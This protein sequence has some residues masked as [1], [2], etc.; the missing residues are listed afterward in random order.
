MTNNE[1]NPV[2]KRINSIQDSW[3]K[4]R[5]RLPHVRLF[6]LLFFQEDFTFVN[7]FLQ[8]E[9]SAHGKTPDTFVVFMHDFQN[10]EQF[11]KTLLL[12]WMSTFEKEAK[13]NPQW[14]WDDLPAL[15]EEFYAIEKTDKPPYLQLTNKLLTSFKA[16]EGK[17]GNLLMVGFVPK[18][19]SN[20]KEYNKAI[21]ALF[22]LLPDDVGLLVLDFNESEKHKDI[23]K[24]VDDKGVTIVIPNQDLKSTYKEL[25]SQGNPNDPQVK[26]RQ[27][28]L[29]M[30][31]ASAN[32]NRK[33]V[34]S[35]GKKMLDITQAT[36]N[37][38]FWA[39]AYLIYA[40]FL[41][42]FKDDIVIHEYLDKGIK[43]A[44]S[45]YK[46]KAE[47][48]G[49][50]LQLY[51]YK[52]SYYSMRGDQD[53]A[54]LWFLKQAETAKDLEQQAQAV[55]AYQYALIIAEK[56]KNAQYESIV[57]KAF[58]TG[59]TLNDDY[60]KTLNFAYIAYHFL[61]TTQKPAEVRQEINLKMEA[62][63]G[64]NWTANANQSNKSL[65]NEEVQ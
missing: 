20:V 8:L 44:K 54:I 55:T 18:H 6:R 17:S 9:S 37:R 65:L 16:F 23:I 15:Q 21:V 41:F 59:Y 22:E 62:I 12:H 19:I 28:M 34:D 1:H 53:E 39:S 3:N 35:W 27:C 29:E 5:E 42:R 64:K 46:E 26:F 4:E 40:G 45:D 47:N 51:S 48:A 2:A 13:E 50:L 24:K 43:I 36:G 61:K 11:Y 52:G 56:Y 63:F 49:V 32:G 10:E 33:E 58:E 60:L 38:S 31:E 7:G 25:A 14:K 30:G 57:E